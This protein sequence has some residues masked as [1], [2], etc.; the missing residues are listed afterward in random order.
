MEKKNKGAVEDDFLAGL[1]SEI[2]IDKPAEDDLFP[3]DNKEEGVVDE[4]V[5]LEKPLPYYKDPKIQRYID[6]QV[7][8]ATQ[9][10]NLTTTET[11]KHE[12]SA[13]DPELVSA[14]T[15]IIGNDTPEKLAALKAL[16][17]SL[18]RVDERAT[19][20]AVEHL[21]KLQ[22]EESAREVEEVAEAEDELEEGFEDIESHYSIELNDRQ[23]EAYKDFL[24]KIEPKGGYVEYPDFV[25]TFGVFKNYIKA[26]RP[27]NAQAKILASRGMQQSSSADNSQEKTFVKTDGKETLWQKF[28][29]M[30]D[31]ISN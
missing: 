22:Q 12:V 3:E 16:E 17:N 29:K 2:D 14:F 9:N 7:K 28:G 30:K 25:E 8:K 4:P 31:T 27:S 20:K 10:V 1:D 15:A 26:N 13:G 11:F 24:L 6:K 23:K 5:V 19:T 21:K 18:A